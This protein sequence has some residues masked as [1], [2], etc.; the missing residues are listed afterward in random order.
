M[1]IEFIRGKNTKLQLASATHGVVE[2]PL[3]QNFDYTPAFDERRI[4][5][6]DSADAVAVVAEFNGVEIR[7]DHF[8]SE[9]KL[10]D[11]MVNDVNPAA[12]AI[13]DDPAHYQDLT[14][15]LNI[16]KESTQQIFQSVLVIGCKLNGAAAAE[17][18]REEAAISRS[19]AATN[20]LRLKGVALEYN[21]VLRSG[22]SAFPQGLAN[23]YSD[24]VAVP[25]LS[26]YIV[27]LNHTPQ[28]V[29]A[30]DPSL[31]NTGLILVLK[32]NDVFTKAV[33]NG[34]TVEIPSADFG[35]N[36]V[37]EIFTTYLDI[38]ETSLTRTRN[39]NSDAEVA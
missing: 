9:S 18:V 17:P 3:A 8:D 38:I 30:N 28:L 37:F 6:F 36:D 23:S 39:I 20:V 29:K 4:F 24:V 1:A 2:V 15:F 14:V 31:N 19:G 7:F 13:V 5:E 10:V 35:V 33:L 25:Y 22:S 32:N 26:K 12:T 11:A 27:N 34:T 21:R 16:R